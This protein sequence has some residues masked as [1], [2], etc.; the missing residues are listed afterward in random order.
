M[1]SKSIW[2]IF[3]VAN[4]ETSRRVSEWL[5]V[6][7]WL[8]DI[9]FFFF[10]LFTWEILMIKPSFLASVSFRK[11]SAIHNLLPEMHF[12]SVIRRDSNAELRVISITAEINALSSIMAASPSTLSHVSVKN[13]QVYG[14]I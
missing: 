2:M 5:N 14:D 12:K 9:R 13:K 7:I 1:I 8:K 10:Y 3:Q 11:F 6:K 4:P